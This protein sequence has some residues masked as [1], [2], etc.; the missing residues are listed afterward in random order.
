MLIGQRGVT[1]C[2][3]P[4]IA[5]VIPLKTGACA[6]KRGEHQSCEIAV[7]LLKVVL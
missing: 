5:G 7:T 4:P 2:P 6:V 3:E 1:F